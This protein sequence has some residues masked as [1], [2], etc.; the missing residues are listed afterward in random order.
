MTSAPECIDAGECG[1]RLAVAEFAQR[2][3]ADEVTDIK[4]DLVMVRERMVVLETTLERLVTNTETLGK[5]MTEFG[6][7]FVAQR[8]RAALLL[9]LGSGLGSAATTCLMVV[10]SA[11]GLNL[12]KGLMEWTRF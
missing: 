12:I 5:Q 1:E 10:C 9:W 7:I 4:E 6:E 11:N 3:L 2:K 8:A